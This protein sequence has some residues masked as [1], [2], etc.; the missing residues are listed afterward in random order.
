[1]TCGGSWQALC[2]PL[3]LFSGQLAHRGIDTLCHI[4]GPDSVFFGVHFSLFPNLDLILIPGRTVRQ[5]AGGAFQGDHRV[6]EVRQ[7]LRRPVS[8]GVVG[9]G[10]ERIGDKGQDYLF[11]YAVLGG[12]EGSHGDFAILG[13]SVLRNPFAVVDPV[14]QRHQE[15]AAQAGGG[16]EA[17]WR[18]RTAD[19]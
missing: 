18:V 9:Y 17:G 13:A 4:L 3:R 7:G 10:V 14:D 1:M 5:G 2:R 11:R 12:A 16:T 6:G 8:L 19:V 15:E